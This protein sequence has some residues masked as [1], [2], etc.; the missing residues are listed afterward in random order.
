MNSELPNLGFT[1][2]LVGVKQHFTGSQC[3]SDRSGVTWSHLRELVM[4]RA[5]AFY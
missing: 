4:R 5:A 1:W 2:V 3:R